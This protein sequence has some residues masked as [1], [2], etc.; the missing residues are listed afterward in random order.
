MS[1]ANVGSNKGPDYK[2]ISNIKNIAG[3]RKIYVAG[4][5]RDEQDL[6][7][8]SDMEING[9]LIASAL[10]TQKVKSDSIIKYQKN[11]P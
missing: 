4:G 1:L 9:V 6:Q 5:V 3:D 8:L 10:H 11:A 2:L 7:A